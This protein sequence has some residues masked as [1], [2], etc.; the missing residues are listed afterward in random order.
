MRVV[1]AGNLTPIGGSFDSL[2]S[3]LRECCTGVMRATVA[4]GGFTPAVAALEV[5]AVRMTQMLGNLLLNAAKL[6]AA[7]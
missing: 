7:R 4:T 3:A 6:N 1:H 2:G 5:D